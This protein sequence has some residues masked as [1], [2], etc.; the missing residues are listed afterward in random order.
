MAQ[1]VGGAY[2]NGIPV[3]TETV[4][5]EQVLP[6]APV[7]FVEDFLY[8]S[9]VIPAAASLE[10]G[11]MWAK[12]IV[13]AGPPTV[14]LGASVAAGTAIGTNT[15][16][17]EKQ[18]ADLYWGD[19]R[20]FCLDNGLVIEFRAKIPVLPTG[21]LYQVLGLAG[22]WVDGPDAILLSAWFALRGSGLV[23]CEIDDNITDR[24]TSSGITVVADAYHIFRID[25]TNKADIRFFIDG[26][27]VATSTTFNYA[28]T[29]GANSTLQPYFSGYKPSGTD[30]GTWTV[31]Y[32][33]I[34]QANRT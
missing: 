34:W 14:A 27:P 24:S 31:D 32:V 33:R 17:S 4:S 21:T 28:A 26:S 1:Q 3:F 10:S 7:V 16:D 6:V 12:K 20:Q 5:T 9:T 19:Q 22:A 11:V 30:V 29:A 25:A 8:P 18:N 15:A 23:Y 2:N 13:G